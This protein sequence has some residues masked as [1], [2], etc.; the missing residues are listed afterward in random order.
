MRTRGFLYVSLVY[1]FLE[2]MRWRRMGD[3]NPVEGRG[4]VCAAQF[5]QS[6]SACRSKGEHCVPRKRALALSQMCRGY[7]L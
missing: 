4:A 1:G 6:S 2:E 5:C 7:Y 3:K